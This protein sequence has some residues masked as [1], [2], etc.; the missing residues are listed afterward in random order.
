MRRSG[1]VPSPTAKPND[2]WQACFTG[3]RSQRRVTGSGSGAGVPFNRKHGVLWSR[4]DETRKAEPPQRVF[5]RTLGHR[6]RPMT[7][8]VT[9]C[10]VCLY[11]ARRATVGS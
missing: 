10:A 3:S 9:L 7:V 4:P 6:G 5:S 11:P 8:K 2:P 1:R